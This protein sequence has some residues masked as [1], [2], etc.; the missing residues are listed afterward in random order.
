MDCFKKLV[1]RTHC[2]QEN[3]KRQNFGPQNWSPNNAKSLTLIQIQAI[4]Y[5]AETT[6]K[7]KLI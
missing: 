3:E 1:G 4:E 5:Q 6:K 7:L 2:P